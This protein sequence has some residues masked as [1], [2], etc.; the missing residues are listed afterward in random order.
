MI[1]A[2]SFDMNM[3]MIRSSSLAGL[4]CALVG[5]GGRPVAAWRHRNGMPQPWSSCQ[6]ADGTPVAVDSTLR[7]L[8]PPLRRPLHCLVYCT[9]GP[10]TPDL[11]GFAFR[12]SLL[13]ARS[14]GTATRRLPAGK[15][16]TDQNC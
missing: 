10:W 11:S 13:R 1:I 12:L 5:G 7:V 16:R 4:A 9:R 3:T 14:A 8:P 15:A 2:R 6:F